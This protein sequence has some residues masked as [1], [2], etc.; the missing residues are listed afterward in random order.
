MKHVKTTMIASA[1]SLS[2]GNVLADSWTI[3]QDALTLD[4][5]TVQTINISTLNMD[6]N[7]TKASIQ[8]GNALI[9]TASGAGEGHI[10]QILTVG[11]LKMTQT[12]T[13]GSHQAANYVGVKF[14]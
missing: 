14:W 8:A 9:T 3:V 13:T 4:A 11:T 6:Q 2:S 1:I 5:A 12:G 10:T 7:R